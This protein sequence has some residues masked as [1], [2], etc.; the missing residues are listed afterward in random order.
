MPPTYSPWLNAFEKLARF[1]VVRSRRGLGD[2][3]L[4]PA[5]SADCRFGEDWRRYAGS[6]ELFELWGP[7]QT[8]PWSAFHRPTLFAALDSVPRENVWPAPAPGLSVVEAPRERPSWATRETAIILDLP[9]AHAVAWAA[10]LARVSGHEPVATF[11]N[12][13]HPK[14]LVDMGETLAALLYFAPWA[15]EARENR[16]AAQDG[17]APP[18]LMLDRRRL[19]ARKPVPRDF[20]NRYYLLES[21]LPTAAMLQR[22]G[23]ERVA[24]VRPLAD[25]A[26]PQPAPSLLFRPLPLPPPTDEPDDLNRYLHELAKKLPLSI[27]RAPADSWRTS[28]AVAWS[29]AIRKTPFTTSSDPAFRGFKRSAA[30]GFGE[31]VPEPSSGGG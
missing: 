15:W 11:N 24:Y 3:R 20:D 2:V 7:P 8:S 25:D 4:G 31:L 17:A 9:G 21:D 13:P 22:A 23:V 27:V 6:R 30:G 19:G 14:G 29:P 1:G 16:L 12:W 5:Q 10:A 28:D 26:Q 18:V